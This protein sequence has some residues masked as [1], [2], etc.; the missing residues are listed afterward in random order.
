MTVSERYGVRGSVTPNIIFTDYSMIFEVQMEYS[1]I[2][3]CEMEDDHGQ[4]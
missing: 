2:C 4:V 3:L 1:N